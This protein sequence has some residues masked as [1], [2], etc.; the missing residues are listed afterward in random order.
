M[1]QFWP[2]MILNRN[3]GEV[4]FHQAVRRSARKPRPRSSPNAPTTP[5]RSADRADLRAGAP[6][7]LPRALAGRQGRGAHQPRLPRRSS[8]AR[9]A[10]TRAA[11]A[12][13]R[14][15]TWASSSSSASS[16]SSRTP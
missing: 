7:H 14:R 3:A 12:S 15:S 4:E 16:R 11:S 9:S 6:D 5:E 10:P 2:R 1:N 13:T 8:T